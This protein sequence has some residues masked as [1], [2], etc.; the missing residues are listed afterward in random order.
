MKR[1]TKI[2]L[3]KDITLYRFDPLYESTER[4][5]GTW[6][7]PVLVYEKEAE[8]WERMPMHI[9]SRK[10]HPAHTF[11]SVVKFNDKN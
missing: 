3:T 4:T 2:R 7:T 6:G 11:A 8:P 1:I 9:P 10:R 5:F